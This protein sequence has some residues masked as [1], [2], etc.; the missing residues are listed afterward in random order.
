M[1]IVIMIIAIYWNKGR[2]RLP[3]PRELE[4]SFAALTWPVI[5]DNQWLTNRTLVRKVGA[6]LLISRTSDK[7]QAGPLLANLGSHSRRN[8]SEVGSLWPCLPEPHLAKLASPFHP[9]ALS[10][11]SPSLLL[12]FW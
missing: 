6:R 9:L 7:D 5:R 8:S 12:P 2:V 1:V 10:S 3:E 4:S 11:P